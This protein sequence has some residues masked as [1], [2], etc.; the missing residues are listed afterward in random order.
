LEKRLHFLF[1]CK[2]GS[3]PWLYDSL[4]EGSL[5]QKNVKIW[6]GRQHLEYRYR[7]YNGV[8]LREEEPTLTMNYL[9]LEIWNEE[10]GKVTY[11]N[12]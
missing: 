6:T 7:W 12:S 5:E 2:P 10:K 8:E 11:R 1:T 4:D 9:S 3:H